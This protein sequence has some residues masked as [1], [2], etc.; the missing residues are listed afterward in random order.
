MTTD[1]LFD[2]AIIGAGMAGAS[3][4]AELA[5]HA[6]AQ[7]VEARAQQVTRHRDVQDYVASVLGMLD[8]LDQAIQDDPERG[9]WVAFPK[10]NLALPQAALGEA[11]RNRQQLISGEGAEERATSEH[12]GNQTASIRSSVGCGAVRRPG[13]RDLGQACTCASIGVVLHGPTSTDDAFGT[14]THEPIIAADP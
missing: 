3:L 14:G 7:P 10:Q 13:R 4:A 1:T 2:F 11:R 12:P 8:Q 5:P 9:W 6:R